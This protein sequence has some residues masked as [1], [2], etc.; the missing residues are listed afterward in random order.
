VFIKVTTVI[1]LAIATGMMLLTL[2]QRRVDA[3]YEMA[4]MHR[5]M[6]IARESVWDY[7]TR[8]GEDMAPARLEAALKDADIRV[9][10]L[11][12]MPESTGHRSTT[13]GS[14]MQSSR[15]PRGH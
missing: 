12:P 6:R 4:A 8:I 11:T 7:H 13:A 14:S 10:S 1:L 15:S 9:E 3:M 5:Q 2:R